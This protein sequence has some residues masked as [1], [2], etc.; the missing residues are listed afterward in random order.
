MFM[1]IISIPGKLEEWGTLDIIFIF[2]MRTFE[3]ELI[4][5]FI[6]VYISYINLLQK[7]NLYPLLEQK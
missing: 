6:Y 2:M 3:K 1:D 4:P 7:E 5:T